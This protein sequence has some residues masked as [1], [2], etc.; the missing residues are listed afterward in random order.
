VGNYCKVRI[1]ALG[2]IVFEFYLKFIISHI[3]ININ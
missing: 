1:C 3:Y 2:N